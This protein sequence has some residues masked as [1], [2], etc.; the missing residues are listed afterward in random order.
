MEVYFFPTLFGEYVNYV[1]EQ[2]LNDTFKFLC[3]ELSDGKNALIAGST[4]FA[5]HDLLR[6]AVCKSKI[7]NKIVIGAGR[8]IEGKVDNWKSSSLSITTPDPLKEK[9]LNAFGAEEFVRQITPAPRFFPK[10]H[11]IR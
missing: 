4:Q 9:I 8:I 10:T 1:S 6:Q 5:T 7:P 3:I 2:H 11:R